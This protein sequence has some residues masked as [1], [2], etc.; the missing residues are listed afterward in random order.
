MRLREA[1]K[2]FTNHIPNKRLESR[3]HNEFSK[4]NNQKISDSINKRA[5]EQ[6]THFMKKKI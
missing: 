2:I 5:K 4:P 6:N 1:Y 3:I